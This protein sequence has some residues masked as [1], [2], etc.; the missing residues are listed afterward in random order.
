MTTELSKQLAK[1]LISIGIDP[2]YFSTIIF[3]T[4]V[5][6]S[7]RQIKKNPE[8]IFKDMMGLTYV[9]T[10]MLCIASIINLLKN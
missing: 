4:L 7:R 6:Y 9:I 10:V 5:Y 8:S 1:A 3:L 2:I